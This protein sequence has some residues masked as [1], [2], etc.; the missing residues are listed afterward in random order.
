MK[1]LY[2]LISLTYYYTDRTF[3]HSENLTI[4]APEDV[5]LQGIIDKIS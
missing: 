2:A 4:P 3:Q 1:N 5:D